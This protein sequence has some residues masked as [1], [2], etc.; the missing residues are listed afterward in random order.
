[1]WP[2]PQETVNLVIFTEETLDGKLHFLYS[3]T[4]SDV[5]KRLKLWSAVYIYWLNNEEFF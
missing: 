4:L 1:M 2:N 3:E 5:D